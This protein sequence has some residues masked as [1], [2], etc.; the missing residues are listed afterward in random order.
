[1]SITL[2]ELI[3]RY[4][5]LSSPV[6]YDVLD[7]MGHPNQA[8]DSGIVPLA[9][10]MVVAGPAFTIEGESCREGLPATIPFNRVFRHITP[11]TVIVSST[12]G[13][14]VSGP[15]GEN[16]SLSAQMRGARGIVL[17]GGTRDANAIVALGFPA[18]CRYVTPVFSKGRYQMTG[19]QQPV[20]LPGQ[21]GEKVQVTPGDFVLA[22]RDGV[23]I[24][25]RALVEDVL[26]AGERLEEIE[27]QIRTS[28]RSGE[29]REVVYERYPKFD[30]VKAKEDS[31]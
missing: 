1:M 10:S 31:Q 15:W 3:G 16:T 8:L 14:T 5:Q 21:V 26:V 27:I 30:H 18:F 23:V 17:D 12:H 4:E 11:N 13:H 28:L 20:E 6:V 29:D 9:A 7:Q 19:Y 24:V 25:P 22:D 2:T